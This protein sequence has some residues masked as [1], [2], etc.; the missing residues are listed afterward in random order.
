MRPARFLVARICRCFLND[1]EA[2]AGSG[3]GSACAGEANMA[4]TVGKC[5]AHERPSSGG[6]QRGR[7]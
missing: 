7:A 2:G 6:P 5:T 1:T 3:V 4:R